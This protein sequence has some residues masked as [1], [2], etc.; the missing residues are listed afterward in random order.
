MA[1]GEEQDDLRE[2]IERYSEGSYIEE[3]HEAAGV[4]VGMVPVLGSPL[5]S[6]ITGQANERKAKRLKELFLAI[7]GDL[8]GIRDRLSQDYLQTE[9]FADLLDRT[10]ERVANELHEEKRRVYKNILVGIIRDHDV[11]AYDEQ[12]RHLR[13]LETIQ[14]AH[15][16]VLRAIMVKPTEEQ[17]WR[18]DGSGF[19][20]HTLEERLPSMNQHQIEERVAELNGVGLTDLG[21]LSTSMTKSGA[22]DLTTGLTPYGRRFVVFVRS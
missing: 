10:L 6:Y 4:L 21:N 15:I 14:P 1:E 20:M 18:M 16:A 8:K 22:Q 9:Q 5:Q 12:L 19:K 11:D 2:K 13:T 17:L 7:A 3:L